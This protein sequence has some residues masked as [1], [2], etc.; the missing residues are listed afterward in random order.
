MCLDIPLGMCKH[1]YNEVIANHVQGHYFHVLE[2]DGGNPETNTTT[3]YVAFRKFE[4]VI[5]HQIIIGWVYEQGKSRWQTAEEIASGILGALR[6][7]QFRSKVG[8]IQP[9][10]DRPTQPS[11]VE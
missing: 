1:L 5:Y 7:G 9:W 4:A 3:P 2:S 11:P 8:T 6:R 10:S